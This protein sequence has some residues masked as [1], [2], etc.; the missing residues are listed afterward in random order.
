MLEMFLHGMRDR[1]TYERESMKH[2]RKEGNVMRDQE[3]GGVPY[4]AAEQIA[5]STWM[6]RS[7]FTAD[8]PSLCYLLEGRDYALLI[9]TMM[10]WGNLKA[11]CETLT[12]LPVRLV[13]THVHPDHT[14]GNF[15]FDLCYMHYR[16]IPYFQQSLGYSRQ[17]VFE[18]ARA[19]ALP[20][21]LERMVMDDNFRDALPMRVF[22]LC[23]GDVFDL[24]GRII[25]VLE[26]PGH[27][28][29]SIVL[30]DPV[31]RLAYT[32]DACNGNT[33]LEFANSMPV[34]VYM[35][36]LLQLRTHLGEFDRMY[37]G[38]EIFGADLVDEAIETVAKVLAGTDDRVETE[39]MF[40]QPVRY[41]A[42]RVENGYARVDGK[43]F[44]MSYVP[45]RVWGSFPEKQRITL[46]LP[47]MA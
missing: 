11:F 9:D 10:G 21:Y 43:H 6:I 37:G 4:F 45:E 44:N 8:T 1:K 40:G 39:G 46:D 17:E 14:G 26:C 29:G 20:E 38:H 35:Q 42:R 25:R 15:H 41:A 27:T 31:V 19:E 34:S 30:L 5:E 2:T 16:D 28:P 36:S 3:T 18:Q 13:N 33:L 7:A 12:D 24:G 22:P 32:G 47:P 23:D